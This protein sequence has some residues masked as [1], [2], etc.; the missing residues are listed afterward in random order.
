MKKTALIIMLVLFTVN[1]FGQSIESN[2]FALKVER[3]YLTHKA[4]FAFKPNLRLKIKTIKGEVI[5]AKSYLLLDSSIVVNKDTIA[6]NEI[7]MIRGKVFG[8]ADRKILGAGLAIAAFPLLYFSALIAVYTSG[9]PLVATLP[10]A[11][12]LIGGISLTGARRFKT[13]NNWTFKIIQK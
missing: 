10:P 13:A 7:I 11:V 5:V 9:S 2:S 3:E 4:S 8:N 6:L 12:F 1:V